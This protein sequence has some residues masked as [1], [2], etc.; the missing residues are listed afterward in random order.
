MGVGSFRE[1]SP[2]ERT[3]GRRS[4]VGVAM[5]L[6]GRTRERGTGMKRATTEGSER[7]GYER[8]FID[9]TNAVRIID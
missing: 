3:L 4:G 7:T 2:G 9:I 8:E 1:S 5:D 6:N